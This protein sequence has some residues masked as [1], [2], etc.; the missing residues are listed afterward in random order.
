MRAAHCKQSRG[1]RQPPR[2]HQPSVLS[3][4]QSVLLHGAPTVPV[5]AT[6]PQG[7]SQRSMPPCLQYG[8][9]DSPSSS[10]FTLHD[11]WQ[12]Y[13]AW[14]AYGCEVPVRINVDGRWQEVIQCYTPHLAGMQLFGADCTRRIPTSTSSAAVSSCCSEG[15]DECEGGEGGGGCADGCAASSAC[16]SSTASTASTASDSDGEEA[17]K[18]SPTAAAAAAARRLARGSVLR[19]QHGLGE[20]AQQP[21]FEFMEVER[22]HLRQPLHDKVMELAEARPELLTLDTRDLHPT[23]WLAVTWVPIYRIPSLPDPAASRDLQANFL[24]FHSLSVPPQRLHAPPAKGAPLPPL[25]DPAGAAA[26]AWRT[27]V[28]RQGLLA[29]ALRAIA[30]Q[31]QQQQLLQQAAAA[32]AAAQGAES[33]AASPGGGG[34][35][36]PASTPPGSARSSPDDCGV[37]SVLSALPLQAACLRP[38]AFMPYKATGAA[39]LDDWNLQR[40]H[41]PMV[42]AAG[43][44]VQRRKV[45]LP[46]FDFMS[47]QYRPL[48]SSFHRGPR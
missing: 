32:A 10:Y 30:A 21:L 27:E 4:L 20:P 29:A 17:C 24:T 48:P 7:R 28:A 13:E 26:V 31:Q 39:W 2:Q 14:S 18:D 45:Q 1:P 12:S 41:L 42:A 16:T 37:A 40:Q 5:F 9:L 15:E 11:L 35:A 47:Q 6:Q 43:S 36:S 34:G 8:A 22:P 23:S 46:D 44:W 3:N 25:L 19:Q 33:P 38:F